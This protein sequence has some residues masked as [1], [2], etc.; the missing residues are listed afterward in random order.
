MKF[1][2]IVKLSPIYYKKQYQF[3]DRERDKC[4]WWRW[5][6]LNEIPQPQFDASEFAIECF[7]KKLFYI[8]DQV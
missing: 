3:Y 7:Q 4:E 1:I 5:F 8:I 2:K 6:P